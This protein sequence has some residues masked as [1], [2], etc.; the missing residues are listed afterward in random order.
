M[1]W[2][3][4]DQH[5]GSSEDFDDESSGFDDATWI[6]TTVE[7]EVPFHQCTTNPGPKIFSIPNFFHRNVVSIM[8]EKLTNI[9]DFWHF[10]LE[11]FE[12]HWQPGEATKSI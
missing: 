9:K 4:V 8:K 12:L 2:N 7:I 1:N 11:P 3:F 10:H 5:V 6:R